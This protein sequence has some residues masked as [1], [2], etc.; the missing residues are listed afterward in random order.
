[1]QFDFGRNWAEFSRQALTAEHVATAREEFAD[2]FNGIELTGKTFLDIGFGQGLSLLSAA[3]LGARVAGCDINPI[4]AEV[5]RR[6]ADLFPEVSADDVP[7][8]VGSILD[9]GTQA[10]IRSLVPG[11]FEIVHSWGVLHHTGDLRRG[12]RVA[13]DLLAPGGY[14]V[15]AIYNRHWSSPIWKCLKWL[16]CRLP[17]VGKKVMVAALYPVIWTAKLAVTRRRPNRHDRGMDF[18]YDVVDWVGGYPYEYAS[19]D[20]VV[21]WME[22]LGLDCSNRRPPR[23]P[24]GCNELVFR[25][26]LACPS[27]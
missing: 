3:A 13:A 15:I 6:N 19:S 22:D 11:G 23:V 27:A 4:C 25:K 21:A 2:L 14:L 16:Y 8:I 10:G 24:T 7:L 18:Y 12:I 17:R 26:R 1:M 20:Q 9:P 5:L